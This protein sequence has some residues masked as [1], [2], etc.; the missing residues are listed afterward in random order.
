MGDLDQ[1]IARARRDKEGAVDAEDF[2]TAAALRDTERQLLAEKASRQQEWATAQP[3]LPS[4]AE[5]LQR[6][7]D[8]V[9]RLRGLLRQHG[10]EPQDAA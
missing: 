9:G 2:E 3:G 7:S 10:I 4:L 6:L 5:G 8:E 1:Q